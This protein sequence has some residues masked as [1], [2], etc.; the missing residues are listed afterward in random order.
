MAKI[1]ATIWCTDRACY[2]KTVDAEAVKQYNHC[3]EAWDELECTIYESDGMKCPD[4]G[5]GRIMTSARHG[6]NRFRIFAGSNAINRAWPRLK[7]QKKLSPGL[8]TFASAIQLIAVGMHFIKSIDTG[9]DK[10]EKLSKS[11]IIQ[12]SEAILESLLTYFHES[13]PE[14]RKTNK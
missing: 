2:V 11:L 12:S 7:G 1:N 8:S 10:A 6:E 4:S 9:T 3:E 13:L 5:C 14:Y